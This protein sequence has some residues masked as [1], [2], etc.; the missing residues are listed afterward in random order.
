MSEHRSAASLENAGR[1]VLLVL[2]AGT[3]YLG[4]RII[5]PFFDPIVIAAILA[6]IVYP[7]FRWL[8]S[9]LRNRATLAAVVVCVLVLLIILGPL[10]LLAVGIVGQGADSIQAIQAWVEAGNF[11]RLMAGPQLESLRALAAQAMPLADP[12]KVD[13]KGLVLTASTKLGNFVA[14]KVGALLSGAGGVVG[15]TLLMLFV[16]FYFVRD[17]EDLVVA[18]RAVSP[19]RTD[20]EE[21]LIE[22]FRIVSRSSLLG[23]LGTAV[24]Q[25]AVGGIGLAIAGLPGIF[26]GTVMAV[27]SLIPFVG[28]ALV[29]VPAVAYLF[30]IERTGMAIFL[31]VWCAAVVGLLD[32]FLR[33]LL[34]KGGSEMSTLWMFFAVL[35]GLQLFGMPGLVYGPIVF[36]LC[37]VLLRLY[38]SEFKELLERPTPTP[39]AVAAEAE[40]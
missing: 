9:R 22:Q 24:A 3:L 28:T 11:E 36:G 35:G 17:G 18:L 37:Q 31:A 27:A 30:L 23:I 7:L 15:K 10:S 14:A 1:V 25:G 4:F 20:Q 5:R 40:P 2:L 38:Q 33:P 29:W 32:N 19:L 34:M 39:E 26:W 6:P 13:L 8:R 16:L 21:S 12:E